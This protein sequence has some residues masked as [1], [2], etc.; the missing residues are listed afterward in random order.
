MG[1]NT[2]R[3]TASS[4]AVSFSNSLGATLTV[5]GFEKLIPPT[6]YYEI[7]WAKSFRKGTTYQ[8]H[9]C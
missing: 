1:K 4:R 6:D 7:E 3:S 2:T 8:A 9:D 5:N